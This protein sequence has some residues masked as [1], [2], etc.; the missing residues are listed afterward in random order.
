MFT[1]ITYP[2]LN[3]TLLTIFVEV[4]YNY[5]SLLL[6]LQIFIKKLLQIIYSPYRGR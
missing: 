2:K 3:L 5:K 6:N 4:H 1:H